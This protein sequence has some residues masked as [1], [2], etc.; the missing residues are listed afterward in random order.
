VSMRLPKTHSLIK[1]RQFFIR[2]IC[3]VYKMQSL[4]QLENFVKCILTVA[5]SQTSS[6]SF[7][8]EIIITN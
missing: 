3:H 2:S 7:E 1:V 8:K 6:S 4:Q 5:L